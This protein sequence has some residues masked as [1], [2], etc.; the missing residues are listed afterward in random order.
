MKNYNFDGH[1]LAYHP[2]RLGEL[3]KDGDCFPIYLEISPVGSCNHRCIFCAYDFIGYPNRKLETGRTLTLMKELAD[4]G[5]KSMLFAGEGEPLLHPDISL[6]IPEARA[7]GIDAGLFTN[8]QLL[9]PGLAQAILPS[10]TFVRFSFN[11]GTRENY[12]QIHSVAPEVFDTVVANI[13]QA[14]S[15][16]RSQGLGV[17]IGAQFVLIPEN[18]ESAYQ[19]ALTLREAG[20]DYLVFKPFV[21]QSSQ[22]GYQGGGAL[23]ADQLE[24]ILTRLEGLGTDRFKVLARRQSFAGCRGTRS[25]RHCYG[26]NFITVL[27]S[28]GVLSSCLPYWEREEFG[29]GSIYQQS[30]R[31][32][33][34][35]A[36]RGRVKR[37]L[38]QQLEVSGCP[39]NCRPHAINAFL[40]EILNPSVE[41]VN[42]I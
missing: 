24:E 12:A 28:A 22:Q 15:L 39:P 17:T 14:V 26:A 29:Y 16:K 8:G 2:E 5:L 4:C 35:G 30:F 23:P 31:E 27:N 9:K 11:A 3:M 21:Q 7:N 1:K 18:L 42:F 19:A 41:H 13:R 25:Y 20:V 37:N 34:Q 36:Q 32:I 10:L 6:L 40:A 33:W 38:E